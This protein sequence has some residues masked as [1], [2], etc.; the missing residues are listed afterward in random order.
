M[1][2]LEDQMHLLQ[3]ISMIDKLMIIGAYA[4]PVFIL[5]FIC[6]WITRK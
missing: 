1:G 6:F 5:L 3:E 2:T 4:L